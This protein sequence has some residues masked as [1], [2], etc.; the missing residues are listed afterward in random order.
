MLQFCNKPYTPCASSDGNFD[1][2]VHITNVCRNVANE[3]LFTKEKPCDLASRYP[4]AFR[5][6]KASLADLVTQS[7]PFLA[8]QRSE[9]HFEFIGV[10]FI[11]DAVTGKACLIE[12]NCPPNNTGSDADGSIDDFHQDLCNDLLRAFVV[13]PVIHKRRCAREL[14]FVEEDECGL[15]EEA[16]PPAKVG[17]ERFTPTRDPS[18]LA[19][20][21][22]AWLVY[23]SKAQK[24]CEHAV[25]QMVA[26][27]DAHSKRTKRAL[28]DYNDHR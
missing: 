3:E 1:D 9:H 6:M 19:R 25:K 11:V 24:D 13:T 20:N 7:V 8:Y 2:E 10:D 15:W 14:S 23:E 28:R 5:S 16:R 17:S 21:G 22:I 4:F 27:A 26:E 18:L 12:C